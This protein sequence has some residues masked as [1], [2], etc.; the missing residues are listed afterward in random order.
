MDGRSATQRA[1][2][3][4][5][6]AKFDDGRRAVARRQ[7]KYLKSWSSLRWGVAAGRPSSILL[8]VLAAEAVARLKDDDIAADDDALLA[9]VEEIARRVRKGSFV[10]N[11]VNPSE[12]LNRLD[13]SEWEAFIIGI[14]ALLGIAQDACIAETQLEAA[15]L[16]TKAFEHFFPMPEAEDARL[17]E[18]RSKA[19]LPAVVHIPDVLVSAVSKTNKNLTFKGTNGIGP[20]PKG[21]EIT[22]RVAEPWKLPP[23]ASVSWAVRNEGAEAEGKNDLGHSGSHDYTAVENSAYVGTHYMDCILRQSGRAIGIRRV[24][25]TI[26]GTYAPPRNPLRRPAYTRLN[27]RR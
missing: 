27:G 11:P 21:C 16:W 7:I 5:F 10:R 17:D 26:S 24:P 4:W 12:N 9:T 20:I 14:D 6:K 18:V 3:T 8:T 19:Q 22:F 1:I 13:K 25:V 23:G 2:Y 15:D